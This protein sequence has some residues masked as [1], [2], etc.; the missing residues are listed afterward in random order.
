MHIR[1]QELSEDALN[2]VLEEYVTREGTDYGLQEYSL[3]Q[4]VTHLRRQLERGEAIIDFDPDTETVNLL[5]V[6]N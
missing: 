2:G 5:P 6:N 4:K 1:W 3:E